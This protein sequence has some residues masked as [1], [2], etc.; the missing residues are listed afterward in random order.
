MYQILK[1]DNDLSLMI[2]QQ[3]MAPD[4]PVFIYDGGDTALFFRDWGCQLRLRGLSEPTGSLLKTATEICVFETQGE[5][6]VRRYIAP[7]RIVSDVKSLM[8]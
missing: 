4:G 6:I 3:P 7:V 5:E 8:A 1:K 2:E